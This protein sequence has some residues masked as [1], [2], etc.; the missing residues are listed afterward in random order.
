M[1]VEGLGE[2][3]A[4]QERGRKFLVRPDEGGED[5]IFKADPLSWLDVY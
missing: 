1:R 5:N 4:N 2:D 3:S